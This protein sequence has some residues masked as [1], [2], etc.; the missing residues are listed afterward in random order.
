MR[1]I[2]PIQ[3]VIDQLESLP[4]IGPKTAQRLAYYLL[5]YP[6]D[7]LERFGSSLT[8]LKLDTRMCAKCH[9]IDENDPCGICEDVTRD[10]TLLCVVETPLDL[11]AIERSGKYR[12]IYHVLH[13]LVNPLAN[14][15]P[16][17][18]FL[19]SLLKRLKA[20]SIKEVIVATN[21]SMEGEATAMLFLN[22]VKD[23]GLGDINVTRIGRGLP[24]G[25]DLEYADD[26]TL[27][28]AFEGRRR[29][30]NG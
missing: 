23:L 24:T 27:T 21:P 4:G 18:I 5:R 19:P 11:M 22:R 6:Q 2:K 29:M 15:G 16:D 28:Q 17:D 30:D 26:M 9:N 3:K 25:A 10:R 1:V 14:I 12:G 13:G 8:R 20:E 7:K